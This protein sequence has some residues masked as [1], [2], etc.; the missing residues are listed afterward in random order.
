LSSIASTAEHL[1]RHRV[2]DFLVV[3]AQH[4]DRTVEL[5]RDVLELH[6]FLF[7]CGPRPV[8]PPADFMVPYLI[9]AAGLSML[10]VF[11][12]TRF[13]DANRSPLRWKTL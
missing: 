1:H 6:G 2:H 3:E 11:V 9:F 12:S 5:Q 8:A 13:L 10:D 7:R 4:G